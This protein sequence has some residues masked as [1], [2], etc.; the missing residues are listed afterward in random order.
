[1]IEFRDQLVREWKLQLIVGK[2]EE[3][4]RQGRTYPERQGHARRML[5]HAQD[6]RAA[7]RS[8]TSRSSRA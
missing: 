4:L 6:R 5:Q 1:M 8:W 3:V 7:S 2:N